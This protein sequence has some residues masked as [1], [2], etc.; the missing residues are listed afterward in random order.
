MVGRKTHKEVIKSLKEQFYFSVFEKHTLLLAALFLLF[1]IL[2][3]TLYVVWNMK[4]MSAVKSTT[5]QLNCF[6]DCQVPSSSCSV[7]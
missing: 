2:L 1:S 3:S 5:S 7:L 4:T 6:V